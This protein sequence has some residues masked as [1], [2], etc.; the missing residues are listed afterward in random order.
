MTILEKGTP[1]EHLAKDRR[2]RIDIERQR[3]DPST[4]N[5]LSQKERD[6]IREKARLTVQNEMK[7]REEKALLDRYIDE[8]RKASDP[9]EQLVPIFLELAGHSEYIM[10]DGV[11][12]FHQ[13][14][15][16]VTSSV[17]AVLVEQQA[18]GWAHEEE[19]EV[20]D[21]K[22]RRRFRAP[23]YVGAQNFMDNRRPRDLEV[24]SGQLM[25]ANP[26]T[27]LGIGR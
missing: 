24:S 10:L 23:S 27:L 9:K 12:Y 22:T 2:R 16:H 11:Q 8:E 18:R 26:A 5:L 19:T 25:G 13:R 1:P 7:D 4:F 6:A 21:T 14:L 20:R 15:H 17:F 3:D